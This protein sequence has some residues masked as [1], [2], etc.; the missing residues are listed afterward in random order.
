MRVEFHQLVESLSTEG[1]RRQSANPG[2]SNGELLFHMT[3]ALILLRS[4]G[5]MVRLWGRLPDWGSRGFAGALDFGT[6]LFNWFNGLGARA[7]ARIYTGERIG[8][9]YDDAHRSAIRMLERVKDEE[10]SDGM[11][12]PSKWDPLFAGYMTLEDVF[13]YPVKHFRFHVNQISR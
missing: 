3:F 2:W 6:P 7:G 1:L 11:H 9:R 12:Y 5:P 8:R 13:R 4:L 10:W